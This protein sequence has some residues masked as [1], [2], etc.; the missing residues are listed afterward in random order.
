MKKLKSLEG[1]KSHAK[2]KSIDKKYKDKTLYIIHCNR[3]GNFY[4]D[5]D[6]LIRVWEQLLGYYNN[7]VYTSEKAPL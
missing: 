7:G 3:T 2:A 1:A 5:T 6:S 4:V